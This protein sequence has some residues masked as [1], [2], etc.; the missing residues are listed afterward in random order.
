VTLELEALGSPVYTEALF[1]GKRPMFFYEGGA[2][3]PD[4]AYALGLFYESKSSNNWGDTRAPR[5]T[6]AWP[7]RASLSSRGTSASRRTSAV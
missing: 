1:T 7:R 2:D 6:P 5:S 4:P 3:S